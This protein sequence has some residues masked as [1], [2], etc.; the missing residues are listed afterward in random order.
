M[1]KVNYEWYETVLFFRNIGYNWPSFV[2][3][4]HIRKYNNGITFLEKIRNL[5]K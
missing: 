5:L 1:I 3:I 4:D 2:D